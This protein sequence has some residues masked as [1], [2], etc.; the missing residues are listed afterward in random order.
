MPRLCGFY[1]G[2]CLTSDEKA[3]KNLSEGSRRVPVGTMKIYKHTVRIHRHNNKN[4]FSACIHLQSYRSD[5]CMKTVTQSKSEEVILQLL[6][7]NFKNIPFSN[8]RVSVLARACCLRMC[9]RVFVC[10]CQKVHN[11]SC[12]IIDN[13][14]FCLHIKDFLCIPNVNLFKQYLV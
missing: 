11:S 3:R 9:V 6:Y 13:T 4:T 7:N 8:L 12:R 1:P 2:I 5:N 10:V 14:L